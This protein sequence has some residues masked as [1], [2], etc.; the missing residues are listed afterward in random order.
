MLGMKI[1]HA[2]YGEATNSKGT[3]PCAVCKGAGA[4]LPEL[5]HEV[6]LAM[7]ASGLDALV[8]RG[9][10]VMSL[11]RTI[12][13]RVTV[14][15]FIARVAGY[16]ASRACDH[17]LA[18]LRGRGFTLIANAK[19]AELLMASASRAVARAA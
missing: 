4:R 2:C 19:E 7:P 11:T 8:S 17:T 1:C 13:T 6:L 15:T 12:A 14:A 16:Q 3:G 5:G 10:E 18:M 9:F